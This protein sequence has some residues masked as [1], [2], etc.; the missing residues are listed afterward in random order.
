MARLGLEFKDKDSRRA[1]AAATK[2]S[3]AVGHQ[4]RARRYR[5]SKCSVQSKLFFSLRIRKARRIR[6]FFR[7]SISDNL[8]NFQKCLPSN[9]NATDNTRRKSV[10]GFQEGYFQSRNRKG[11]GKTE[12]AAIFPRTRDLPFSAGGGKSIG[13]TKRGGF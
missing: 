10:P 5:F 12:M 2:T 1:R 4:E 11:I 9:L 7:Q 8:T 13:R 3:G 6:T